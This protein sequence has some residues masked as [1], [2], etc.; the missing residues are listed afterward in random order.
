MLSRPRSVRTW[1][2]RGN[3]FADCSHRPG[4][5]SRRVNMSKASKWAWGI[6]LVVVVLVATGV[7]TSIGNQG[8]DQTKI[9]RALADSIEASKQGR[10]GGVMDLLSANL[11]V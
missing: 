5:H 11:K 1:N 3:C 2:A 4:L 6:G 9:E 10:P 7:W 8:D